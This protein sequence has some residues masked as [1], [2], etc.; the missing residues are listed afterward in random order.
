MKNKILAFGSLSVAVLVASQGAFAHTRLETP[1]IMEGTRV[2]NNV[3]IAHGC[4]GG[5][6]SGGATVFNPTYG[7]TVVFPSIVGS[8][9]GGY[10]SI[11]GVDRTADNTTNPVYTKTPASHYISIATFGQVGKLIR[12]GGPFPNTVVKA[13][14]KGNTD[15]FA[16][17]GKNYDQSITTPVDV[18]FYSGAVVISPKSCARS[19]TLEFAIADF[20][21]NIDTPAA[22][23]TDAQIL[24]WSPI[25][26]FHGVPGQPFGTPK[27]DPSRKIPKGPAYS[28]YDGYEDAA[29][30]IPGD[31]WGSPATLMVTR[32]TATNPIP[33]GCTGNNGAGD[34]V[35]IY[36]SAEQINAELPIVTKEWHRAK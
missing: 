33:K 25:P 6:D 4:I 18:D 23:A 1:V 14:S 15:G 31:G 8:A 10:D 5:K 32:N 19:V 13:D 22:V 7:T 24:F 35:Y 2:H 28:L 9:N 36:P 34:D 21:N 12:T 26:N 17:W 3:V 11:V 20:C 16:A 30:T 27:G 29:H